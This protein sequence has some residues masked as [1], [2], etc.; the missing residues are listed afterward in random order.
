MS[1]Y[2]TAIRQKNIKQIAQEVRISMVKCYNDNCLKALCLPVSRKL[3][4]ALLRNGYDAI[5]VQGVFTVDNPD[6]EA[7]ADWD[8][9]DFE[10]EDQMEE[11]KYTPLHYWVEV[12]N[13]IIDLTADQF[14]DELDAPVSSIQIGT[15]AALGRYTPIHKDWI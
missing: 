14:N 5:V 7:Y 4:E 12:G 2:K 8:A 3:K 13:T 6:P 1:W 11:A 15:Y 9:N 10:N